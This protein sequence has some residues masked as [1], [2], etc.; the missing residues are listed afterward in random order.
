MGSGGLELQERNIDVVNRDKQEKGEEG[1]IESDPVIAAVWYCRVVRA[2]SRP[3]TGLEYCF[4]D[5]QS[6]YLDWGRCLRQQR[7][8]QY[9]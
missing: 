3:G 7:T 2:S 9:R 8:G 4:E 6:D 1:G 5:E